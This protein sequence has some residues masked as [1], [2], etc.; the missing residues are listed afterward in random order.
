V[1]SDLVSGKSACKTSRNQFDWLG[2]G[3][4]FW[5]NSPH[6]AQLYGDEQKERGKLKDPVIIGAAINLGYCLDLIDSEQ[7]ELLR[8]AYDALSA[9]LQAAGEPSLP[10]NKSGR[11]ISSSGDLLL[12]N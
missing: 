2:E 9:T 1:G 3:M 8:S 4:Y 12:R 5:E 10:E 11:L 6:R 7:I